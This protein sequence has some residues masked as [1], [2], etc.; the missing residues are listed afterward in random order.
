MRTTV[1][2][3]FQPGD[4]VTFKA[5]VAVQETEGAPQ[6]LTIVYVR[7]EWSE[8]NAISVRYYCRLLFSDRRRGDLHKNHQFF[9]AGQK[10]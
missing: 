6:R 1:Y 3:K 2:Y 8:D 5:M 9:D 4:M 10:L 7:A